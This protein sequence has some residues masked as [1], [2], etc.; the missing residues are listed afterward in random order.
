LVFFGFPLVAPYGCG[1]GGNSQF[2]T[3][4]SAFLCLVNWIL[5]DFFGFLFFF[6]SPVQLFVNSEGIL[7]VAV[8]NFYVI[9]FCRGAFF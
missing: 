6:G 2:L 4:I 1:F 9:F 5:V 7:A 3:S 8:S